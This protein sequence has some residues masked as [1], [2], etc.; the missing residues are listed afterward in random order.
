MRIVPLDEWEANFAQ[1]RL[2]TVQWIAVV[3]AEVL[4]VFAITLKEGWPLTLG[5]ALITV[6][7]RPTTPARTSPGTATDS[8]GVSL[9]RP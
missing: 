4:T 7:G 6:L 8:L 1:D 9:S 5:V 3:L 2:T